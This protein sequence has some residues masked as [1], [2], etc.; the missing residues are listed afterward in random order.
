MGFPPERIRT[1][2]NGIDLS[3]ATV[4]AGS[5]EIDGSVPVRHGELPGQ[6]YPLGSTST[7]VPSAVNR[8]THS[9]LLSAEK[10]S[11]LWEPP[12]PPGGYRIRCVKRT[13]AGWS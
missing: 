8:R 2:L 12:L 4:G 11:A 5:R 7:A 3:R 6:D 10:L 1:I 13:R 9:L